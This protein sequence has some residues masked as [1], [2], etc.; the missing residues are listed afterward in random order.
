MTKFVNFMSE[1]KIIRDTYL[2]ENMMFTNKVYQRLSWGRKG[3][4]RVMLIKSLI[5]VRV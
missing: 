5:N 4:D 3:N 1:N 2:Y